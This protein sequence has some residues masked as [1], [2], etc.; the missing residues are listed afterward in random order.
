MQVHA[1]FQCAVGSSLH[2]EICAL[3]LINQLPLIPPST[4]RLLCPSGTH[5]VQILHLL[6][7][8]STFPSLFHILLFSV[9]YRFSKLIL[10]TFYFVI[11]VL[12]CIYKV[13]MKKLRVEIQ[14]HRGQKAG[15]CN[16][17]LSLFL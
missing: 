14:M 2:R 5:T 7:G 8:L 16:T 1:A 12:L 9:S 17:H 10:Q 15:N 4:F 11:F 6:N 13:S 3:C